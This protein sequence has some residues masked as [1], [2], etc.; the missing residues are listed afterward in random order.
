MQY[1]R[2]LVYTK[3]GN[4]LSY[5]RTDK[6]MRSCPKA[7][8]EGLER[9]YGEERNIQ[10]VAK[11]RWESN[12]QYGKEKCICKIQC[13]VNPLPVKGEFELPCLDSLRMFLKANGWELKQDMC[14]GWFK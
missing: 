7:N 2:V 13:P 5:L 14:S 6:V 4:L 1:D 8:V 11:I 9:Y 10:L 3:K 12:G